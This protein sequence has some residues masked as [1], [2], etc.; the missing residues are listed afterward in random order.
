MKEYQ[1]LCLAK[2]DY[3]YRVPDRDTKSNIPNVL[4][5]LRCASESGEVPD[6]KPGH[7]TRRTTATTGGKVHAA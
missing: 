7:V 5:V 6:A 2:W 4:N 1:S 3:E